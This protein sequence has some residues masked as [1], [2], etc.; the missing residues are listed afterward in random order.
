MAVCQI[1]RN[2]AEARIK[3][4][5][6]GKRIRRINFPEELRD[7]EETSK[8]LILKK[9]NQKF[10]CHELTRLVETVLKAQGYVTSRSEPRPDGGVGI[11]AGSAPWD[12]ISPE[13]A[14]KLNP[15]HLQ[16]ALKF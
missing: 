4:M 11:L 8:D 9:I 1:K 13:Y 6:E 10:R 14:S 15:T 3:A 12:S 16:L 2:N 7:I 5:L